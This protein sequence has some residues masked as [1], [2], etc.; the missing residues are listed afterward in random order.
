MKVSVVIPTTPAEI[1]L[2]QKCAESVY[3]STYKNIEILIINEGLERSAQRNLGIQRSK[4]ECILYLDSDQSVSS[5]LIEECVHLIKHG[6][7]SVYI[8]EI[9]TTKGFFGYLRNWERQFYT[10][11]PVDCARFIRKDHCPLFDL[12]LKGPEDAD[13]DRRVQGLKTTSENCLYHEDNVSLLKFL[14]KKAYYS[15]SMA[16]YAKRWPDD[17]CLNFWW[18]CFFCYTENGKYKRLLHRP[19]L[20]VCLMFLV[21]ARGIVYLCNR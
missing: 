18:R 9:I 16:E 3:L 21:L 11:T 14:K 5:N 2:A 1:P 13:H 4:G 15:K 17:K 6:Y 20:A 12:D 8:P 7:S 19:D 10:S